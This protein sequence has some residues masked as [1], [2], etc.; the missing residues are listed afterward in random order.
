MQNVDSNDAVSR[1]AMTCRQAPGG[2]G[3][4]RQNQQRQRPGCGATADGRDLKLAAAPV[5]V[6]RQEPDREG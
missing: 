4:D 5:D 2:H 1:G 6:A 3:D